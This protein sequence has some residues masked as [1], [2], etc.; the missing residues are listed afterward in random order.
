MAQS[1]GQ[2]IDQLTDD[3][4]RTA[5]S[6][7]NLSAEDRVLAGERVR[8]A[9]AAEATGAHADVVA[10]SHGDPDRLEAEP[11][12]Q[13][14]LG[15]PQS[16]PQQDPNSPARK[17]AAELV[18]ADSRINAM[19]PART[20]RAQEYIAHAVTVAADAA[21]R[22]VP[23]GPSQAPAA[24]ALGAAAGPGVAPAAPVAA[25]VAVATVGAKAPRVQPVRKQSPS[26]G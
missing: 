13:Y 3:I 7:A 1:R 11:F 18:A 24:A 22:K 6:S 9:I 20:E 2:L 26:I 15:D 4:A 17:L 16:R 23:G 14:T 5:L 12:E 19:D 21:A 8:R 25:P 10:A